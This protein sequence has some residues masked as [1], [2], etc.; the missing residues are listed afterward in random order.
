MIQL[1][2][3]RGLKFSCS[4]IEVALKEGGGVGIKAKFKH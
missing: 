4:D 2:T 3:E 1:E